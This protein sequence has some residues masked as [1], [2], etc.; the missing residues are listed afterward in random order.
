MT[1]QTQAPAEA[2]AQAA[3]AAPA[4]A[5]PAQSVLAPKPVKIDAPEPPA[6]KAKLQGLQTQLRELSALKTQQAAA[7]EQAR[8]DAMSERERLAAERAALDAEKSALRTSRRK[9]ALNKLGILEK[10][11][12]LVPDVDPADPEGARTL[13]AW[14]R[15]NPEFVRSSQPQTAAYAAPEGSR[16]A[17]ILSGQEKSAIISREGLRKLLGG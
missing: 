8:L 14:A 4:A 13:E 16:L 2:P 9:D 1:E 10:A 7:A 11:A 6:Y 12:A 3:V 15:D 17:K 5:A